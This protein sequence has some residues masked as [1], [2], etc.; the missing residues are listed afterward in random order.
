VTVA[1]DSDVFIELINGKNQI[2][3]RHYDEALVTGRPVVIS[4]VV[5]HEVFFG[6]LISKRPDHQAQLIRSFA[7]VHEVVDWT[8]ADALSTARVRTDLKRAGLR[9]GSYDALLA[10]QAINRNWI[11]AT[12]N[13][14][15]YGR[16]RDLELE[17]WTRP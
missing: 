9:I 1:I 2:V 14:R 8:H 4:V 10:G 3:R 17:N 13:R 7:M 15:E 5:M 12:G 6:A 11:V 16:V